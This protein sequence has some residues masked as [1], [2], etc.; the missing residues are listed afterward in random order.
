MALLEAIVTFGDYYFGLLVISGMN[1]N[2]G[3]LNSYVLLLYFVFPLLVLLCLIERINQ[4]VV[5]HM[6]IDLL[7]IGLKPRC[8]S[9]HNERISCSCLI[10]GFVFVTS[11]IIHLFL[12]L[13]LDTPVRCCSGH[14]AGPPTPVGRF[15]PLHF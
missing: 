14:H 15:V 8:A 12:L 5:R 9:S 1:V 2:F 3:C 4:R 10:W 7:L 13:E 6:S 11:F